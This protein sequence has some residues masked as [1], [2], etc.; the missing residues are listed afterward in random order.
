MKD[1]PLEKLTIPMNIDKVTHLSFDPKTG[2]MQLMT[3]LPLSGGSHTN[4]LFSFS[5]QATK[6]I[7]NL[8]KEVF[9]VLDSQFE[10]PKDKTSLQ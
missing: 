2:E 5:P 10:G 8:L 6:E 7:A 4:M 1:T 3:S 9:S